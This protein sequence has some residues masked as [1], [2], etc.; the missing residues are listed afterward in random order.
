MY[1]AAA[2]LL[3]L[4]GSA[5]LSAG[6]EGHEVL[7]VRCVATL[8]NGPLLVVHM[9]QYSQA[10]C[11]AAL[12]RCAEGRSYGDPHY[13][14]HVAPTPPSPE[15]Q[16]DPEICQLDTNGTAVLIPHVGLAPRD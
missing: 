15:G 1:R 6:T 8:E 11:V 12:E 13:F 7:G 14:D 3:L 9:P 5:A 10:G 4:G 2:A 16:P